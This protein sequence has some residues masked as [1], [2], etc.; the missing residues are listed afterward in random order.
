MVDIRQCTKGRKVRYIPSHANGD[1]HHPD[2]Q[3]GVVSSTNDKV[4][5]V[6]YDN[7]MCYMTTG[8]EPYTAQGTRPEDL[9]FR[10]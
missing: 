7:A 6:K 9:V 4:V 3:N 10:D 1:S 8:D 5:F 2:C